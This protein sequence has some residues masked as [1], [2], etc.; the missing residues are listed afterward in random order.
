MNES[1][2]LQAMLL[3]IHAKAWKNYL[4]FRREA[5]AN[6]ILNDTTIVK[7]LKTLPEE[8]KESYREYFLVLR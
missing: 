2:Y 7:F 5:I 6:K 4:D 3:C 8:T 1:Q